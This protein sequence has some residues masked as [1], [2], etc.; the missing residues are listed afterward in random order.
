MDWRDPVLVQGP[1]ALAQYWRIQG[2][3]QALRRPYPNFQGYQRQIRPGQRFELQ[4][5]QGISEALGRIDPTLVV[6]HLSSRPLP[7]YTDVPTDTNS[8]LI[9]EISWGCG[10]AS[11][12]AV[13]DIGV[14]T[15]IQLV[16][17]SLSILAVYLEPSPGTG[18]GPELL[19]AST[20]V[21]GA[22]SGPQSAPAVTFTDGPFDFAVPFTARIPP[23]AKSVSLQLS[24]SAQIRTGGI[25]AI[26]EQSA[27]PAFV[28]PSNFLL[29]G[30]EY[31]Q[32][33]ALGLPLRPDANFLR[34]T[35][36][37]AGA[38]LAWLIYELAL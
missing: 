5:M 4:R 30:L 34:V 26:F 2:H 37:P 19:A 31:G 24:D 28:S 36:A 35:S 9:A 16:A 7:S 11:H 3:N 14:G 32:R 15:Q 6:L 1:E 20:V 38:G 25:V 17:D 29:G 13:C 33:Y 27:S 18:R 21:Y 23:F 8:R 12:Q 10:G 22:R